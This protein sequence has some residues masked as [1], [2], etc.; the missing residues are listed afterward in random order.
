MSDIFTSTKLTDFSKKSKF[1]QVTTTIQSTHLNRMA[2]L[3]SLRHEIQTLLDTI[4]NMKKAESAYLASI[5]FLSDSPINDD[6]TPGLDYQST[7]PDYGDNMRNMATA[8]L[9]NV[10]FATTTKMATSDLL[11]AHDQNVAIAIHQ[12]MQK[13]KNE[14]RQVRYFEHTIKSAKLAI[15]MKRLDIAH[16]LDEQA[17]VAANG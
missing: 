13:L 6:G 12:A 17:E 15:D 4:V 7:L 2:K 11:S 16:L 8:R 1:E 5:G 9:S 10:D 14:D 3:N